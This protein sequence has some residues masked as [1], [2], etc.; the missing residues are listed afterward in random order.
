MLEIA[1]TPEHLFEYSPSTD[2]G[3]SCTCMP[4]QN[5]DINRNLLALTSG[6]LADEPRMNRNGSGKDSTSGT[7]KD[8][9]V[10]EAYR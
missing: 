1:E 9:M 3:R 5:R 4:D 6:L 10:V 7:T 8:D 2:S